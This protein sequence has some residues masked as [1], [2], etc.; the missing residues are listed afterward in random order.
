MQ[1]FWLNRRVEAL[2]QNE[3]TSPQNKGGKYNNAV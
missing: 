3:I 2:D 1:N